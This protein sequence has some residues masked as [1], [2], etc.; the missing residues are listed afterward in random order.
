MPTNASTPNPSQPAPQKSVA[1]RLNHEDAINLLYAIDRGDVPWSL[2]ASSDPN[3]FTVFLDG[4]ETAHTLVLDRDG[5]WTMQTQV[6][7]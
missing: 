1:V 5:S 3:H 2:L 4:A 7:I 6:L